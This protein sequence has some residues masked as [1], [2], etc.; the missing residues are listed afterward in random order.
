MKLGIW[1]L[2]AAAR[3]GP[4]MLPVVN[5][6]PAFEDS[7]DARAV[8]QLVEAAAGEAR[9]STKPSTKP[10]STAAALKAKARPRPVGHAAP[11]AA[12]KANV[13]ALVGEYAAL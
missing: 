6:R 4:A 3:G 2:E 7:K 13:A 12:A 11:P 5:Q 1:W 10:K 9:E 8:Q